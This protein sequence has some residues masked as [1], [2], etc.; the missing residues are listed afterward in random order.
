MPRPKITRSRKAHSRYVPRVASTK[1]VENADIA[2]IFRE[3][4]DLLEIQGENEFRIRAYRTAARVVEESAEPIEQVVRHDGAQLAELPGIG[5]DLA[6]KI[7]EIVRTGTL[8]L[9]REL[10]RQAPPGAVEMMRVAGVG[11]K[12]ARALCEQLSVRSL[13]D[14]GRAARAHRVRKLRGFGARTEEKIL[15]GLATCGIGEARCLRAT[16][17][18]YAEAIVEYLRSVPSVTHADIGGSYRRCRETVGDIDILVASTHRKSVIEQFINYPT[19]KE[20]LARGRTKASVRLASGLQVDLRVLDERCYGAGLH[21]FTGSKAHNIAVRRI[22]RQ[23]GLKINEYGVFRGRRRIGGRTEEEVFR[24]VGLPYI[25]PEL[26][27]ARGEIEAASAGALPLLLQCEDIRGDL[28]CHTTDSDGRASL[29]EMAEAAQALGYEYL[30]ITDHSPSVRVATGLDARG[31]RAQW[32]RIDKLNARLHSLTLLKGAEV[33][34]RPDGSLDLGDEILADFDIVLV[35]LHSKLDLPTPL[36]TKRLLRAM[37]HRAVDV[38]A[39]PT[40][41]LIGSRVGAQFDTHVVFRA[42]A[43]AGVMLEINAQPERLDLDDVN[44]RAALRHGVTLTLG[45]DS[46]A[47]AELRFMRWGIDQ[48]RRG[49]VT[50]HDVANTRPLNAL[51][52]LLHGARH[53]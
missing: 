23:R 7:V 26:R 3:I 17:A 35:S 31:F 12:R 43:D 14:L 29:E 42:A 44:A 32:K 15:E 33:D 6:S 28:Q 22:G 25:P 49:W 53:H 30:A 45:S 4:S 46:H 38:I 5:K 20:V 11:P 21:Y 37:Q 16:A 27:E 51:L 9:L 24:A 19:V 40:G 50:K 8:P 1:P 18:E 10:Q 39:H 48:A 36:Q 2:R 13:A 47:A 52:R 34:I 41:R